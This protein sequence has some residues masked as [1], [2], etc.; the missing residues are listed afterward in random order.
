MNQPPRWRI[1]SFATLFAMVLGGCQ[2]SDIREE[3]SAPATGEVS[4]ENPEFIMGI[5][6]GGRW[7]AA[8]EASEDPRA[9]IIKDLETDAEYEIGG[10]A[11]VTLE[12]LEWLDEDELEIHGGGDSLI[13]HILPPE[14][15]IE[16]NPPRFAVLPPEFRSTSQASGFQTFGP[17]AAGTGS[18]G[19]LTLGSI[20][21]MKQ[22]LKQDSR[23]QRG[24]RVPKD[25]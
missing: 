1:L 6:S 5:P 15:D 24:P 2:S 22:R 19:S 20:Q 23:V 11:Q 13:L 18:N 12:R 21:Y 16:G 8:L 10:D 3:A 7:I 14:P 4:G 9:V 17:A 25:P